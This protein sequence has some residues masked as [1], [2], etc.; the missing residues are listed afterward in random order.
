MSL[1]KDSK[2]YKELKKLGKVPS[3]TKYYNDTI[4]RNVDNELQQVKKDLLITK[5][6]L[7]NEI[8]NENDQSKL[9][10]SRISNLHKSLKHAKYKTE[11]YYNKH[12]YETS[13]QANFEKINSIS[14]SIDSKIFQLNDILQNILVN[15]EAS[16]NANDST[17]E[18]LIDHSNKEEFP[19]LYEMLLQRQPIPQTHSEQGTP[20]IESN[21]LA[22]RD[23]KKSIV[24][25]FQF[26]NEIIKNL[27]QT[28]KPCTS[29]STETVELKLS[30]KK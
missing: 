15:L 20:I 2:E 21:T 7:L 26:P 19:L 16:E 3:Y 22:L 10:D 5:D 6:K 28:S 17:M 23:N 9:I 30:Y 29:E 24:K 25:S 14:D 8:K 1:L 12:N 27:S 18:F 13:T 11:Q 4:F